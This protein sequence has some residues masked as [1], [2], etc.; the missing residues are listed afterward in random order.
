MVTHLILNDHLK[1]KQQGKTAVNRNSAALTAIF[2]VKI[3][4]FLT[5]TSLLSA[6]FMVLGQG[7]IQV[8]LLTGRAATVLP[9]HTIHSQDI[10]HPITISYSSG[11]FKV[12]TLIGKAGLRWSLSAGGT[13]TRKLRGIPDD[14]ADAQRKGW[15]K[16][17]ADSL[18]QAFR[19]AAD[20]NCS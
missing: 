1:N 12:G 10:Q 6:P 7:D 3:L 14:F 17:H 2:S 16:A 4:F 8:D 5:F 20:D 9:F 19:P 13:I 15:L 11:G 18:T